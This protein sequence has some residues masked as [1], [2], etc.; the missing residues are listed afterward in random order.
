V[1]ILQI[2]ELHPLISN[3]CKLYDGLGDIWSLPAWE[4]FPAAGRQSP[5]PRGIACATVHRLVVKRAV[6]AA[7]AH[8][9]GADRR[10]I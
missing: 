2:A 4:R 1:Q 9:V 3:L 8:G 5:G 10:W 7:D 6:V